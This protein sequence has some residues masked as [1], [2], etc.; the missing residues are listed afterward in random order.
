MSP[1]HPT[2]PLLLSKSRSSPTKTSSTPGNSAS[3]SPSSPI[4]TLNSHRS[5]ED[6]AVWNWHD[7]DT[8]LLP[9]D[10]D[11]STTLSEYLGRP[12]QLGL[13]GPRERV[14]GP[15]Q[16]APTLGS[17]GWP[18]PMVYQDGYPLLVA[19]LESAREVEKYVRSSVGKGGVTEKWKEEKIVIERCVDI[20][21]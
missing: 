18:A 21:S 5:A 17:P 15:T 10:S 1:S 19:S 12:V 3:S 4:P 7:I 8:Y 6:I 11:A 2:P 14:C 9:S 13:K 16:A 20:S